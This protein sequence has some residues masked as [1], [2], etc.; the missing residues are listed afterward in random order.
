MSS[1]ES[2]VSLS[3]AV[4]LVCKPWQRNW[5]PNRQPTYSKAFGHLATAHAPSALLYCLSC[6][7]VQV[8]QVQLTGKAAA[9]WRPTAY[10]T[11][12][13]LITGRTHQIRAQMAA[14]GCPLLGDQLYQALAGMWQKERQQQQQ[15]APEAAGQAGSSGWSRI[16][17]ED[18]L[19]P[20]GLQAHILRVR[21]VD[22]RMSYRAVQQQRQE[23]QL[24]ELPAGLSGQ[25]EQPHQEQ[26]H[27]HPLLT[28][29]DTHKG[30]HQPRVC[31]DGNHQQ[32]LASSG[33]TADTTVAGNSSEEW[34]EF[35]TGVPWW[36]S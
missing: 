13:Q 21:D 25:P 26:Q 4:K 34:L 29:G 36:R 18:P 7:A 12:L 2:V 9:D 11:T 31:D 15:Q 35:R 3:L 8:E 24:G 19:R 28:A 1:V 33:A 14:E 22:G 32:H 10:E 6:A 20:I 30:Q 16:Y 17:Q 27:V 5:L 23:Q